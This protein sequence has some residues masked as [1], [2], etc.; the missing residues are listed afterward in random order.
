MRSKQN[1]TKQKITRWWSLLLIQ[2]FATKPLVCCKKHQ[3]HPHNPNKNHTNDKMLAENI[4]SQE[5]AP[6]TDTCCLLLPVGTAVVFILEF[7]QEKGVSSTSKKKLVS[8]TSKLWHIRYSTDIKDTLQMT[9]RSGEKVPHIFHGFSFY[10][11]FS[12]AGYGTTEFIDVH[13]S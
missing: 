9:S 8:S 11:S 7:D 1:K 5:G 6:S 10:F 13:E 3:H 4:P 2:H 12:V